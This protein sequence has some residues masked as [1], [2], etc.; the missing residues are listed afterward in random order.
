MLIP[1]IDMLQPGFEVPDT[2]AA[3]V[4]EEETY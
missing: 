4:D 3:P 2:N 1:V